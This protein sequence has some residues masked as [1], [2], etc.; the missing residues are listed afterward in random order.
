[1]EKSA[2]VLW[3]LTLLFWG[4][5]PIIEKVGLK[6][7]D[8]LLGLF[9]RTSFS[10]LALGTTVFLTGS[11]RVEAI[12]F[13]TVFILSLSGIIG[14]FLGMLTYFSLLKAKEASQVVPLT[15]AYP[16]VSTLLAIFFLK[17][18]LTLAKAL[19]ILLVVSGLFLL[20]KNS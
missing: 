5:C 8:P 11:F 2:F 6:E 14:G 12:T 7:I 20:F 13:K 19:G 15:S 17:E 4:V 3:I 1:M 16:L 9:I 10:F 18:S